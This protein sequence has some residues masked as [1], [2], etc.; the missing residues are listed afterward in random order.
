M[1][2]KRIR[3]PREGLV[4]PDDSGRPGEQFID[5]TTT[6]RATACRLP[7]PP[8]DFLKRGR[9]PT[10]ARRCRPT[11]TDE[12]RETP[13]TPLGAR[14]P[15]DTARIL[16]GGVFMSGGGRAGSDAVAASIVLTSNGLAS[17]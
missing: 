8:T 14:N 16:P 6:S 10:A 17:G 7:A 3:L 9:R 4:E 15:Q 12:D 11:T 1:T 5:D 2:N 13:L